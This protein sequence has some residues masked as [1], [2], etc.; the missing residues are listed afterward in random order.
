MTRIRYKTVE[1]GK[2][3]V[4]HE[5]LCGN[6]ELVQIELRPEDLSFMVFNHKGVSKTGSASNLPTLKRKAKEA[7]KE[8]GANFGTESRSGR[9]S[10]QTSSSESL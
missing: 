1:E 10:S 5:I 3:L 7:V 4:S 6:N 8:L 9:S 2:V